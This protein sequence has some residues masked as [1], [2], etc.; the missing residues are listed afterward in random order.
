M[1]IDNFMGGNNMT[2]MQCLG[3]IKQNVIDSLIDRMQL[4]GRK[5]SDSVAKKIRKAIVIKDGIMDEE[6]TMKSLLDVLEDIKDIDDLGA[7]AKMIYSSLNTA[8]TLE[9]EY[10]VIHLVSSFYRHSDGNNMLGVLMEDKDAATLL[11]KSVAVLGAGGTG[12]STMVLENYYYVTKQILTKER[13]TY[14]GKV[15]PAKRKLRY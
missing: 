14:N 10:A 12:K 5:L 15:I 1:G 2:V 6:A 13:K 7:T 9:Q 11:D 8:I 4:N 3:H